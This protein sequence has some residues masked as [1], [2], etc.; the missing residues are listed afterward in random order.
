MESLPNNTEEL[1]K[2]LYGKS[3]DDWHK[4]LTGENLDV[5]ASRYG[6]NASE[7]APWAIASVMIYDAHMGEPD[8]VEAFAEHAMSL[9][10]NDADDVMEMVLAH[11]DLMPASLLEQLMVEGS[12]A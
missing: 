5:P 8:D 9:V 1:Q 11:R 7:V 4:Q 12:A 6:R 10:V 2:K 3:L